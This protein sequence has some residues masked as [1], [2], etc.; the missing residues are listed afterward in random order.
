MKGGL[1]GKKKR[2]EEEEFCL[3][4]VFLSQYLLQGKEGELGAKLII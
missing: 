2:E 1:G 4:R 3:F